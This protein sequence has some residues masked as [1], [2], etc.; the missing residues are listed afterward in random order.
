MLSEKE[1]KTF[2]SCL[3]LPEDASWEEINKLR[4][5][6]REEEASSLDLLERSSWNE[7]RYSE[8]T[9]ETKTRRALT[10]NISRTQVS[11][12]WID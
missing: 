2:A 4:D 11:R 1:R 12:P 3:G 7:I 5:E 10:K 8:Y 9:A 6:F